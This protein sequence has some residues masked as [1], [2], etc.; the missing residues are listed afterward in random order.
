MTRRK[1]IN[2][3]LLVSII[4]IILVMIRFDLF[5]RLIGYAERYNYQKQTT[6][7]DSEYP[8]HIYET[9]TDG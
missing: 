2:I 8:D 6:E 1:I 4:L 5:G 3:F 7:D 9:F